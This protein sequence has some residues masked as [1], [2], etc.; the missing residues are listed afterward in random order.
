MLG[1]GVW[2]FCGPRVWGLGVLGFRGFRG[3]G[4]LGFRVWGFRGFRGFR[5]GLEVRVELGCLVKRVLSGLLGLNK[6]SM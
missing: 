2:G 3:L 5:K 1:F 6:G 4:D